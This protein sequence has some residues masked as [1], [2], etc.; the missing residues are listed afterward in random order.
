MPLLAGLMICLA[1][2]HQAAPTPRLVTTVENI[3]EYRLPNGVRVLLYPDPSTT[4]VTVNCTIFVGSRHEGYGETGMAHLLEHMVFKGT[5]R[6]PDVPKALKDRGAVFNGT[7][8]VDRTNYYETLNSEKDNL[9]F[10]IALE[11]DRMVNSPIRREDL[12]SEMTV[13]RNE[14]ERGENSPERVLSQRMM[15]VAFEWHNYGKSTIG[16]RSD[17]ERVPVDRLR[18]FYKK[19]YRPD[20][21]MVVVAGKFEPER[22]LAAISSSFGPLKNPA[23]PLENTY[24][25]EPVQDGE[26][27]VVL[28]RAGGAPSIGAIYHIP[29]GSHADFPAIEVLAT[30]L[31]NEP[32]G[33]LYK[34]LVESKLASD[35]GASA[36]SWHDP[37]AL[38][39][40]GSVEKSADPQKALAVLVKTLDTVQA[41]GIDPKDVE[42][43]K[44]QLVR[45]RELQM[46]DSNRIGV[47]LSEWAA[48][49][50]WRLFFLHRD[51]LDKVTAEDVKR[52]AG[53]YLRASNRTTGLY[54]PEATPQRAEIPLVKDLEGTLK[55]YKGR[56]AMAAG[57]FF[58]P[59]WDNIKGATKVI[60]R[61]G[62]PVAMLLPRKT[63]NEQVVLQLT[64]RY[65]NASS[66][67]GKTTAAQILPSL[68]RSG[69]T[70]KNRQQIEDAINGL[71][72]SVS[73]QGETG[74]ININVVAR[75]STLAGSLD[76]VHDILRN[77]SFPADELEIIRRR[78]KDA[79]E[80]AKS[81]PQALAILAIQKKFFPYPA[82]DV[83]HVPDYEARSALLDK[84]TLADVSGLYKEQLGG[85]H[86]ELA[87]VGDFDPPAIE[88]FLDKLQAGWK[89]PVAHERIRREVKAGPAAV[90]DINTPDK[91]NAI[92][93]AGLPVGLSEED[94]ADPALSLADF[95]LGG[96]SLS[97]R[98]GNRIR[99]KEGL[100]YGVNSI[101]QSVS[102]EKSS[103]LLI[104]ASV[105]PTN[106]PKAEK[107]MREELEKFLATGP[108][109][110][111]VKEG[112]EALLSLLKQRRGSESGQ[113]S[114]LA[115]SLQSGRTLDSFK[116]DEESLAG[117]DASAVFQAIKTNLT[118]RGL[119]VIRAADQAKV[120]AAGAAKP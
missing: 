40:E 85:G 92:L 90:I 100:A 43:A 117:L 17:I 110:A 65:G 102:G 106:L 21:C 19:Y 94:P 120:K 44:A 51:R 105:N 50:D 108:D 74:A 45:R 34:A 33:P 66:L 38:E 95:I 82:T 41:E 54:L 88:V 62:R 81:E 73:V 111:E 12:L 107:A 9:E 49:G 11:A 57:Q 70:T 27:S 55:D 77:P 1:S 26:R 63:R 93:L 84:V 99:Q 20:N 13:V 97:S 83:R 78:L 32:S 118:E 60:S 71:K 112:R 98:L 10:A 64:L 48:N 8:W 104:L 4:K 3:S 87:V 18:A 47:T 53:I 61:D 69:T 96:G 24:T 101:Y 36:F 72:A 25:E 75:R 76:L 2:V 23:V 37:G 15:A 116:N 56:S 22:A 39:L 29:A 109:A 14:F 6:H 59:G 68:L 119:V 7:T 46:A 80:R 42:R 86:V 79:I 103:R 52:V 115:E 31:A 58:E 113:A 67:A 30:A 89:S 114:I 35:V 91:A 5:P 16:N 28:K